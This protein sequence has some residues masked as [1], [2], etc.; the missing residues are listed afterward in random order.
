[1]TVG[2][3][4][5]ISGDYGNEIYGSVLLLLVLLLEN[6]NSRSERLRPASLLWG[7]LHVL[8]YSDFFQHQPFLV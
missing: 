1:V 8:R 2:W 4:E 5:L 7:G 3:A 6:F